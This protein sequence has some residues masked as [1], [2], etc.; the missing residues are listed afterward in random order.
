MANEWEYTEQEYLNL[1]NNKSWEEIL[2]DIRTV[3]QLNKPDATVYG[4]LNYVYEKNQI[5][6]KQW[7]CLI[8]HINFHRYK[9]QVEKDKMFKHGKEKQNI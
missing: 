3:E 5:S 9:S 6:F 1:Y 8:N 2:C 4:I 7:K